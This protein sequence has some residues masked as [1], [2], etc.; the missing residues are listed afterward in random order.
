MVVPSLD[1]ELRQ[2]E[3]AVDAHV[4]R[5]GETQ[6]APD[7]IRVDAPIPLRDQDGRDEGEQLDEQEEHGLLA[8]AADSRGFASL[9]TFVW[10]KT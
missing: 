6:A 2:Y 9:A 3:D 10:R 1:E 7:E 5:G 8:A 4:D